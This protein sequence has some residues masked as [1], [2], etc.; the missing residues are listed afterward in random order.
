MANPP[1]FSPVHEQLPA[2]ALFGIVTYDDQT[3][4]VICSRADEEGLDMKVHANRN[5][6][7]A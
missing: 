4:G 6:F 3:A 5:R 1:G 2:A 7:F